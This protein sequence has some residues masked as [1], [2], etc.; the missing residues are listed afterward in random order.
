ML[1]TLRCAAPCYKQNLAAFQLPHSRDDEINWQLPILV[2]LNYKFNP[3]PGSYRDRDS[4]RSASWRAAL[5]GSS[6]A[7]GLLFNKFM[8]VG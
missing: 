2:L 7:V 1:Q 3:D 4:K 8:I 5:L 6:L